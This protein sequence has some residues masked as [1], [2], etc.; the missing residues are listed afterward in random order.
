MFWQA[1]K[2]HPQAVKGAGSVEESDEEEEG[3]SAAGSK[4]KKRKKKKKSS[5][6]PAEVERHSNQPLLLELGSMFEALEVRHLC[7]FSTQ[8]IVY[9][10]SV[11][12]LK[13]NL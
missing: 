4:K 9:C 3:N 1:P 10:L 2:P 8:Y 11:A 13:A 5:S 7:S 12:L 6:Q